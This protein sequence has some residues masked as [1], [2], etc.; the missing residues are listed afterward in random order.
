MHKVLEKLLWTETLPAWTKK[1]STKSKKAVSPPNSIIKKQT[2]NTIQLQNT[3]KLLGRSKDDPGGGAA[4]QRITHR[5]TPYRILLAGFLNCLRLLTL[6]DRWFFFYF[7][8]QCYLKPAPT[9]YFG[10]KQPFFSFT[11]PQMERNYAPGWIIPKASP[12]LSLDN[13]DEWVWFD[14]I[15]EFK[16]ISCPT[17]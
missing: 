2:D 8:P 12:I 7:E 9:L 5:T 15:L 11:G 13:L 16:V 1:G 10:G 4:N 6:L 14:E 17:E 3:C